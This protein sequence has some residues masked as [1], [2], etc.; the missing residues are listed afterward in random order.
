MLLEEQSESTTSNNVTATNIKSCDKINKE[1]KRQSQE[2]RLKVYKR[3]WFVLLI[4]CAAISVRSFNQSCYGPINNILSDYFELH[5][6]QIDWLNSSN[7]LIFVLFSLPMILIT[8]K[9]G[10]LFTVIAMLVLETISYMLITLGVAWRSTYSIAMVGQIFMATST[11]IAASIPP[12]TAAI[13]FPNN[14]V[15]TAVALHA[16]SRGIGEAVGCV[17]PSLILKNHST[18]KAVSWLVNIH[19]DYK[20]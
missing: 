8:T 1:P 19:V 3:R 9:L 11:I 16:V 15:A 4:I 6:W 2:G 13:W 20:M 18:P 7:A 10:F 5:P 14:E 12:L 17:V